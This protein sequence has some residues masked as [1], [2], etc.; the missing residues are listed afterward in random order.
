MDYVRESMTRPEIPIDWELVDELLACGSP[1]TEVASTLGI[2]E[3]TLYKRIEKDFNLGFSAYAAKKRAC[4][5]AMIRLTQY[6]K[7][8]GLSKKG[9]NT[10]LIWLGKQRLGQKETISD[11]QVTDELNK[12]FESV[13]TQISA[14][15]SSKLQSTEAP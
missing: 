7:A 1:G 11:V 14:L 9:D 8:V 15:Q 12:Q 4:G 10:L 2:H 3:D 5:E 6:K 13:M